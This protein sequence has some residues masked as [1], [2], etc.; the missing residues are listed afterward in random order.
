MVRSATTSPM[1]VQRAR[2]LLARTREPRGLP[3]ARPRFELALLALV[4]VTTL[5]PFPHSNPQDIS[6]ICLAQAALHG[7]LSN[8]SCLA[9]QSD[10]ATYGGHLYSDKA[11]GL[12]L[13]ELPSVAVLHPLPFHTGHDL[14]LLGVRALSVGIALLLCAFLVGRVSEGLA[15][16][17]GGIALVTFAL[18]T[19]AGSLAQMS[20]EQVPAGAALI[21]AFLLAWNRRPFLAGLAGGAALLIEYECGLGVAVI[22]LY[23]AVREPRSLWRYVVGLVPGAAILAAY[24]WAAFG[25]PWHLSY[26]YVSADFAAQ[27]NSGLFGIGVPTWAGISAVFSGNGGL[28]FVSPVLVL[29]AYGLV[30]LARRYPLES[31]VAGAMTL[32]LVVLD[33]GYYLPYGGTSPGPRF[34][35][36]ALPFLALGLGPVFAWR[37]RLTAA[38]AVLSV[39]TT[40]AITLVWATGTTIMRQTVWGE[41]VRIPSELGS[42]PY[43]KALSRNVVGSVG[44]DKWFGVLAVVL[45]ASSAVALALRG[46]PWA[47]IRAERAPTEPGARRRR[48][49]AA[50][51]VAL[52]LAVADVG[53]ILGYPYGNGYQ[54]R[55]TPALVTLTGSPKSSYMGGEVN[56]QLIVTNKSSYLLLPGV[57]LAVDLGPGMNLVGPPKYTIGDGCTGTQKIV[58]RMN[59][60]GPDAVGTV[61]FSVQFTDA[62]EHVVT[63][64]VTS[65]GFPGPAPTVYSIPVGV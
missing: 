58:C 42:S 60:L 45:A 59:Y 33:S 15:P 35:V 37:T 40:T 57:V 14:G 23:V 27:Q 29:A 56:F 18:G 55:R 39:A 49:L 20:F 62:G 48:A 25:A 64:H 26:R 16:G 32:L 47:S 38:L 7:H 50:T 44:L 5:S 13:L 28:L 12:S 65:N 36:P 3:W 19:I 17:F 52:L 11:P 34:L 4:A 8:S 61:W 63:A 21:G 9:G 2:A 53:A 6:R 41:L 31:L 22:A 46:V 10:Y 54:P 51:L 30:R 24:D 1:R 43:V